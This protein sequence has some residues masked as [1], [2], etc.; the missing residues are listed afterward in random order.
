MVDLLAIVTDSIDW[1]RGVEIISIFDDGVATPAIANYMVRSW[2]KHSTGER[3]NDRTST[4][5]TI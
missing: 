5:A 4:K 1:I 2:V 3:E